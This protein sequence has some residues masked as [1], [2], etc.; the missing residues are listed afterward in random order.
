MNPRTAPPKKP[1]VRTN[2][3]PKKP[4]FTK[5]TTRKVGEQLRWLEKN[6]SKVRPTSAF[7]EDHHAAIDVQILV[8][9]G[10][11]TTPMGEDEIFERWSDPEAED[12]PPNVLESALEVR[13]WLD[14]EEK[15]SPSENWTPLLIK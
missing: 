13:R 5:P 6:R 7:G 10:D 2:N 1:P 8:L 12:S 9:K 4:A 11:G 14:G 3:M 15:T